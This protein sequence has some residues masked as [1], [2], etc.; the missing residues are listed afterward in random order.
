MFHTIGPIIY[1]VNQDEL[2]QENKVIPTVEFIPT[3]FTFESDEENP[4]KRFRYMLNDM[5]QDEDRNIAI[6]NRLHENKQNFNLVLGDGL[7]HLEGLMRF[8][9]HGGT[10]KDVKAAFVNG[11]TKKAEREKIMADVR[12][13]KFNYLFATYQLCKEGLDIPR[14][15]RL[16]MVT[17]KRDKTTIQ[18]SVGRIMRAFEGKIDAKVYDFL[19]VNVST[20]MYQA[21]ARKT[22]Y[23]QLGCEIIG[24]PEKRKGNKQ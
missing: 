21:Q 20:C 17:P 1:Q 16:Y 18:Q 13:G 19:D 7:E 22:V 14:L 12:A 24:W 3:G 11:K 15:N 10:A 5:Q 8:I 9:T 6:Y 23:K 2:P 4:N